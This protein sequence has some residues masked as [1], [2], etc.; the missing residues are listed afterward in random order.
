VYHKGWVLNTCRLSHL[1]R[2][3][4]AHDAAKRARVPKPARLPFLNTSQG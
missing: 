3:I 1:D 2:R 4:G